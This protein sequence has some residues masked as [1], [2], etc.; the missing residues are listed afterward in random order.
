MRGF[1]RGLTVLCC[2]VGLG[3]AAMFGVFRYHLVRAETGWNL[4]P[5]G[6][7]VPTDVYADVRN[8]TADDWAKHPQLTAALV[9]AGHGDLV[10]KT[11]ATKL[12][13]RLL[14][15]N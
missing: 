2:G 12:A 15:R 14:Q 9:E 5:T 8:W 3:A 13:N 4:V 7:S 10:A 11:A 1:L 6:A